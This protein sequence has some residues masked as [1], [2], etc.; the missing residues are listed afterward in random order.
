[1][2][3]CTAR[4]I[5]I[6]AHQRPL[7][8]SHTH[9]RRKTSLP[10]KQ[11]SIS[12]T[13]PGLLY[14]NNSFLRSTT[15]EERSGGPGQYMKYEFDGVIAKEDVQPVEKNY[16]ESGGPKEDSPEGDQMQPF[17]FLEKLNIKK[18]QRYELTT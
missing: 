9:L 8:P 16:D 13:N 12:R 2:D 18:F 7:T 3:L 4:P 5:S 15:S 6:L 11:A 14:Y 17:E 10:L 1:M